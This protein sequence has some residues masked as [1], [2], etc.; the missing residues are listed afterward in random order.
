MKNYLCFDIGGTDLKYGLLTEE[1]EILEKGKTPTDRFNGKAILDNIIRIYN[2]FKNIQISGIALSIPGFVNC[3]TGYIEVGGAIPDFNDFNIKEYLEK[4]L[5]I[6]VSGENDVNCVALA[7]KWKG[8]AKDE[9]NFLCMTIGTG[10][11]GACF[12]NGDLYRGATYMAGEFGYMITHGINNNVPSECTLSRSGAILSLR[13]EYAKAKKLPLEKVT[14]IDVFNAM[15]NGDPIAKLEIN[16]FYDHLAVGIHNLYYVLN[17]D[18]ILIGGAVSQREDLINEL[19]WRVTG[20]S[21]LGHRIKVEACL[22]KNDAGL[23]GALYH[24]LKVIK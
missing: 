13:E 6:P 17:P 21:D 9:D 8:S 22:L 10:I 16:K 12:L 1:G 4:E 19:S 5:N 15:E 20:L 23:I 3:F 18:K 2:E 14:G 11:G 24:H 7:E